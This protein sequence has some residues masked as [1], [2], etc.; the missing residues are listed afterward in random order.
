[1]ERENGEMHLKW[2]V[3][4]VKEM[5]FIRIEKMEMK[6]E[7]PLKMCQCVPNA[8]KTKGHLVNSIRFNGANHR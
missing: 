5:S 3:D 1:M 6:T 4:V 8:M 2:I 7:I